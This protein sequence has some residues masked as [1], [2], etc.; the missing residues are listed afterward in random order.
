MFETA[1]PGKIIIG[2]HGL[3][4]KPPQRLLR[5]WWRLA[6]QHGMRQQ[7][8]AHP[9]MRVALA[10]WA[11]VR[12]AQP[13]NPRETDPAHPLFLSEP[14]LPLPTQR[15]SEAPRL[16][17]AFLGLLEKSMDHIFLNEDMTLNLSGITNALVQQF[18][19]DLSAYLSTTERVDGRLEA[20]QIREPLIRLLRR[21][22][23][24]HILLIAHSMGSVV[25]Y[26][27]LR[28]ALPG[29]KV[30]TLLTMGCPLGLPFFLHRNAAGQGEA[31][32]GNPRVPETVLSAWHN[33]S[34]LHDPIAMNYNLADDYLPSQRGVGITDRIVKN[35]YVIHGERNP[36]KSFGYLQSPELAQICHDFLSK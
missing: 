16:R 36:H 27:V 28:Q 6:L 2:I 29:V 4:N 34:D 13:L 12:Y 18:F 26:D 23:R 1:L 17:Q 35:G 9:F 19:H 24:K 32:S 5:R 31:V 14:F 30:H 8:F 22:R 33:L 7:G 25:A 11:K 3:N 21:H 15:E 20:D 10:Y